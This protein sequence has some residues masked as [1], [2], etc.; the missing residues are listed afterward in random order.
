MGRTTVNRHILQYSVERWKHPAHA[1]LITKQQMLD[2]KY[3]ESDTEIQVINLCVEAHTSFTPGYLSGLP[4]DCY[5]DESSSDID[6]ITD[7]NG[8]DWIKN[9]STSEMDEIWKMI[10]DDFDRHSY[11]N[12]YCDYDPYDDR[13]RYHPFDDW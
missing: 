4:E 12:E 10:D 1:E 11:D 5:P 9:L 3:E 7:E 2:H 6:S 8:E 13:D